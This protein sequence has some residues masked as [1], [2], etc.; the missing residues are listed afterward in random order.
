MISA[1][2][3]NAFD[4][5]AARHSE[6][7]QCLADT[8]QSNV[9]FDRIITKLNNRRQQLIERLN[10]EGNKKMAVIKDNKEKLTNYK[11]SIE[12]CQ[13]DADKLTLDVTMDRRT[14]KF[15]ILQIEK[16]VIKY[17]TTN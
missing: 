3:E 6:V 4:A 2:E 14:R 15:R 10:Y 7:S 13:A 8:N 5:M 9:A 17:A 16:Y 12:S 11:Q 1:E